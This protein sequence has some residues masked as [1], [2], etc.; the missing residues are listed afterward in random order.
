MIILQPGLYAVPPSECFLIYDAHLTCSFYGQDPLGI[1]VQQTLGIGLGF[2]SNHMSTLNATETPSTRRLQARAAKSAIRRAQ[3]I[4]NAADARNLLD[5]IDD[6]MER[7]RRALEL[8]QEADLEIQLIA[9]R[10][11][12]LIPTDFS[13]DDQEIRKMEQYT[14]TNFKRTSSN[15]Y[16]MLSP[17]ESN[18]V[19]DN[20]RKGQKPK[21]SIELGL[22]PSGRLSDDEFLASYLREAR[23]ES[24]GDDRDGNEGGCFV[25]T[26]LA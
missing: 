6:P 24:D 20:L 14:T 19:V 12:D 11:S 3:E 1:A 5:S 23:Y 18:S 2:I 21:T 26:V 15:E 17:R 10:L 4:Y 25:K 22:D 7:D 16:T 13:L 9:K 8:R